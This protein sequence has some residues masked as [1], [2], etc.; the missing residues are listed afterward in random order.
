MWG[1]MVI[2]RYSGIVAGVGEVN[3]CIPNKSGDILNISGKVVRSVKANVPYNKT[4][5]VGEYEYLNEQDKSYLTL[6]SDHK[7][8]Y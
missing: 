6:L 2:K 8:K 7:I 3:S 1:K 4:L 5:Y